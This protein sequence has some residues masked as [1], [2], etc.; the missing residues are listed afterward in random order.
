ML[1]SVAVEALAIGVTASVLGLLGGLGF[2]RLIGAL[3]Q[4]AGTGIP[5]SDL[6]LTTRTVIVAVAVG[7]GITM[8]AAIGP[9]T[10]ATRIPP[11]LALEE[12]ARIEPSRLSRYAPYLSAVVTL[13]G[14]LLLL[15]GL[16]GSGPATSKL[17]GMAGGAVLLFIGLALVA[18]YIVR[19]IAA[20][21]GLPLERSFSVV[22]QLA[23]ENA[24][25]NPGRT[26][27]T[28]AALMVG[29]GLVVFVA[30]FAAGLKASLNDSD[31]PADPGADRDPL[32]QRIPTG[33][34]TRPGD[35]GAHAR[36]GDD[37]RCPLRPGRGERKAF[38]PPL[39]R[40]RRR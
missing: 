3:F 39:R 5:T 25:R 17:L 40:P 16:F 22:G 35:C 7:I 11:A 29:L 27:L 6:H 13:G 1:R 34:A 32:R 14:L 30:V 26:A 18:R 23:R 10:R 12:G 31:R 4:A 20:A 2:A 19:P 38:E 37:Q 9:A 8:V 21:I 36:G 15:F 28:S 33:A 24:Q